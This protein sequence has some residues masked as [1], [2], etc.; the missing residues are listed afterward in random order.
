MLHL[1]TFE[2]EK[3]SNY[4]TPVNNISDNLRKKKKKSLKMFRVSWSK[5]FMQKNIRKSNPSYNTFRRY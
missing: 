2:R 5:Y 3:E 4:K 1:V